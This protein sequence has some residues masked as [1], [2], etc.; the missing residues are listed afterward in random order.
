VDDPAVIFPLDNMDRPA[1]CLMAPV[2]NDYT[3]HRIMPAYSTPIPKPAYDFMLDHMALSSALARKLGLAEYR[4]TRVGATTSQGDDG[5]GSE[6]LITLLYRDSTRRLYHMKG[7]HHGKVIPMITGEAIILMDYHVQT[8]ADGREQVETRI[9]S[10]SRIDNAFIAALVKIF[11]PFL[12]GVVDDKVAQGFLA[13]HRLGELMA[14]DPERVY[15]QAESVSDADKADMEALRA[16]L[17]P[18]LKKM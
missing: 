11:Q 18:A 7:R 8:G 1:L 13:V 14:V 16:L 3:T 9:T 2:V 6:G 5:H 4:I 17:R 15:R 10:Y 12:R